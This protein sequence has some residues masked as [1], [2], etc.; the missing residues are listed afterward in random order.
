MPS[1]LKQLQTLRKEKNLSLRDIAAF[2]GA[3][4]S[5]VKAW[6]SVG[7]TRPIPDAKLRLLRHCPKQRGK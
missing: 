5:T 7:Q 1:K 6:F 3:E 2:L 4:I